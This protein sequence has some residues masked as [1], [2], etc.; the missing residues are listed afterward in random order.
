MIRFLFFAGGVVLLAWGLLWLV[1]GEKEDQAELDRQAAYVV[2]AETLRP[3]AKSGDVGAR[4]ALAGMY[5]EGLGVE[6]NPKEAARLYSQAAE[7]GHVGAIHTLGVLYEKGEG[8][9]QSYHRAAEWYALAARL[10]RGADSQFALGQL[11]FHGRGVDHDYGEAQ[12]WYRKAALQGHAPSQYVLG[13]MFAEGWGLKPDYV[14]AYM[15]Y[16]LALADV[17]AVKAANRSFDP[18]TARNAIQ[19]K[20]NRAQIK[21]GEKM[22]A[23]WRPTRR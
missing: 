22:A 20:M 4:Y 15:W 1:F 6:R 2:R 8:V 3:K 16:T 14:Q 19:A 23:E 13:A 11:Y 21:R 17:A 18:T 10:G 5:R 9:R 12:G 7:T